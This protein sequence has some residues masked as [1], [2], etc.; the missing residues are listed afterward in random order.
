MKIIEIFQN[1]LIRLHHS[2]FQVFQNIFLN[3]FRMYY[4]GRFYRTV[5]Q[6]ANATKIIQNDG[7]I[8]QNINFFTQQFLKYYQNV[9]T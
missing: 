3:M 4:E 7:K 6:K 9:S 2:I 8:V 1:I 5:L